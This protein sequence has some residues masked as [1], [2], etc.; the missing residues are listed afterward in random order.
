[1]RCLLVNPEYPETYWSLRHMLPLVRRRWLVAPLPLLTVAALLPQSWE[2]R[3]VDLCVEPLDDDDLRG[4]DVVLLSGMIVQRASLH[5]V[6]ERCRRLGVRTVVGGP[7]ATAQPERLDGADHLVLGEAEELVAELAADLEAGRARRVYRETRKPDLALSPVP[8]Y[9]LLR[10]G[11]YHYLALQF[12]RGCPFE[13]EFCDIITLYGRVPRTKSPAQ[14]VAELEAI[15]ATGFRGR[16]MFVDDN[17]IG[18]RKAVRE[19]LAELAAWRRRTRAPLD[20]FTEA[21]IDLADRPELVRAMTDAGFAAVFVGI[22]TP[23]AASLRETRKHQNLRR[24]MVEQVRSLRRRGLDVWAGFILGFDADGPDVFDEMIDFIERA[25][26]SYAMVGM[27]M[28]LPGTPLHARLAREGRL[29]AEP[30]SGDMFAWT[31]VATT[32]SAA[33]LA[34]GYLRVLET[35]YAPDAY[36]ARCHEHLRHWEE[37]PGLARATG[38]D[39]LPVVARSLWRQGVRGPYRRAYWRF[40]ASVLRRSPRKLPLALAQACA[41]HHFLT[42]TRETLAPRLRARLEALDAGGAADGERLPLQAAL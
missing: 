18:A 8:R 1:V 39:D 33:E 13:C 22:E 34:A 41:G 35:L 27:L 30:A 14:V 2:L 24:D 40:L 29:R 20:F 23:R 16:V 6:L 9:D 17:F 28:A 31:N 25:G 4:A 36:F 15:R 37:A 12:S 7:Y 21:S 26:I 10:P 3:L 32:L 38:W 42:Y 19:L 11:L 5:A